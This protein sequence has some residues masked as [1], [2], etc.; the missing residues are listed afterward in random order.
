M[1]DITPRLNSI[2]EALVEARDDAEKIDKGKTGA[3][4]TRLRKV[5][6][7]AQKQ[8]QTLRNEVIDTRK[9]SV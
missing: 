8:L 6:L 5:A 4:G 2:I 1:S 3:P 9:A 7:N